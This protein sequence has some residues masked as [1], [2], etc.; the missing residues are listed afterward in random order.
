[1]KMKKREL[2]AEHRMYEKKEERR[3][4]CFVKLVEGREAFS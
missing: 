4:Q 3:S 1:M 2:C